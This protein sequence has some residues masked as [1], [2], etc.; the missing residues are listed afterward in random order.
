MC[1]VAELGCSKSFY[2][3]EE[4]NFYWQFA[5]IHSHTCSRGS[6]KSMTRLHTHTCIH[7]CTRKIYIQRPL[8]AWNETESLSRVCVQLKLPKQNNLSFHNIIIFNDVMVCIYPFMITWQPNANVFFFKKEQFLNYFF[9]AC[10][11]NKHKKINHSH[12]PICL[13]KNL[14]F[15]RHL[16]HC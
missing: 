15:G 12:T 13:S 8:L 10:K 16:A 6:W 4:N 5:N 1:Y 11:K 14:A 9:F 2:Q 3:R 7:I